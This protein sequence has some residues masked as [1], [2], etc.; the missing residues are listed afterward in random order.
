M[1]ALTFVGAGGVHDVGGV[2]GLDN[3]GFID[4]K[5]KKLKHWELSVHA[6]LVI[7]ASRKP[8]LMSTDELRRAVE[9]LEP[10]VYNSWDYYD[11]WG[12]AM[13]AILMERGVFTQTQWDHYLSG[14]EYTL[15]EAQPVKFAVG[16]HVRIRRENSRIRWRRPH[17]R[18]PGYVFGVSGVISNLIGVFDDP[19]CLAFRGKGPKQP[20]Y[21]VIV[22]LRD[23]WAG[24]KYPAGE[25]VGE[26]AGAE[27]VIEIEV[28]QDWLELDEAAAHDEGHDH[29]HSHGH[30]HAHGD[31]HHDHHDH[32]G[33]VQDV[34][35][36]G[37]IAD[38]DQRAHAALDEHSHHHEHSHEHGHE[39]AHEHGHE[40]A[41]EHGHEH[42]HAH[43]HNHTES[44]PSASK[45]CAP[46]VQDEITP[47]QVVAETL[48][49]LLT[50]LKVISQEQVHQTIDRLQLAGTRL[51]GATLV[52]RAWKDPAFKERLLANPDAAGS[53][54]DVVTSNPNAPTVLRVV[55]NSPDT[56]HAVVCTLCSCYPAAL[57][58][59][60]PAWYKSRN[61]R[62]RMVREPRRVLQET[63]G[64]T[65]PTNQRIMVHD[66]TA[67]C[68]YLVLPMPPKHLVESGAIET[69]TWEELV[70]YVTRNSMVGVEVL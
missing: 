39:H 20:L 18:C 55:A 57:L 59:L 50:E 10:T 35:E 15:T 36:A 4:I 42:E 37:V 64:L 69:M 58:G 9:A 13:T 14:D 11:R 26:H 22:K 12:A 52:A 41:H 8:P 47:G 32:E 17:I 34:V 6:L 67:D 62:A 23:L 56:H 30:C 25:I 19:F 46:D 49:R 24:G 48:L 31:C 45:S 43:E 21:T 65:L 27:D 70:P 44:A 1:S 33:H 29:D 60:S 40:H 68:R 53:E 63:F 51:S 28:Y 61:Y 54:V 2:V 66:S 16:Q 5:D 7:L 38:H 3:N